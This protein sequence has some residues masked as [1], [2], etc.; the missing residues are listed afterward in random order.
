MY[1][2]GGG[3]YD[4]SGGMGNLPANM[5]GALGN[6]PAGIYSGLDPSASADA[7]GGNPLGGGMAGQA[8]AA[9]SSSGGDMSQMMQ[10]MMLQQAMQSASKIGQQAPI[11][12]NNFQQYAQPQAQ[13]S[14]QMMGQMMMGSR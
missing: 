13:L 1:G 2:L 12:A 7:Y 14:P 11:Q 8:A 10:M 3:S 9:P 5:S 6:A 4:F